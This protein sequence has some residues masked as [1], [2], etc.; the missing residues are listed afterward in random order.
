M[1]VHTT[2]SRIMIAA[3]LVASLALLTMAACSSGNV[4]P[5]GIVG[6]KVAESIEI[7]AP[8]ESVKESAKPPNATL[9][10]VS[11]GLNSCETFQGYELSGG[12]DPFQVRITNLRTGGAAVVC[13]TEYGTVEHNIELPSNAIAGCETYQVEV[14]GVMYQVESNCP[15][16][17]AGPA[18]GKME[19][20]R[21]P[22]IDAQVMALESFPVQYRLQ[23]ES[24][25]P[26]GCVEF[27]GYDVVQNEEIIHVKVTNLEPAD[28]SIACD[29][30]FRTVKTTVS[31]GTG[32][33]YIPATAYIVEVNEV[34]TGFVTDAAPEPVAAGPQLGEEFVLRVGGTVTINSNGPTVELVEIVEDSRCPADVT[35]I[36][37]GRA[38]I[39]VIVSSPSDVLGF[40]TV[41]MTLEAGA[42]A[43]QENRVVGKH[44]AYTLALLELAPQPIS[45]VKLSSQDYLAKLEVVKV[46]LGQ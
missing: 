3:A 39:K 16:I 19:E 10:I 8:I 35:C 21:A 46:P 41:D 2:G 42:E 18:F 24:A 6:A 23:I 25:L 22:I 26:N 14:N 13:T 5:N 37:A 12:G 15:A 45:T 43:G 32:E 36:W 4:G 44:A 40:G 20:V 34:S 11:G 33:D 17:G 29:Q 9:V 1:T 28:K 7:P 38:L 31:L 27:G 30:E